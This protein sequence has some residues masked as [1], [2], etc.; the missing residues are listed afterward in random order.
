MC[1]CTHNNHEFIHKYVMNK[2]LVVLIFITLPRLTPDELFSCVN[3]QI[4]LSL[5]GRNLYKYLVLCT[6]NLSHS[7][8]LHVDYRV[9]TTLI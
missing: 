4:W 1:T 6:S 2:L 5:C 7:I 9:R 3:N 8:L